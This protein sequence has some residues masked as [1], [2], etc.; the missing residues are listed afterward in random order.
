MNWSD[1]CTYA[2]VACIGL[3][4]EQI[5]TVYTLIA[6]TVL[7][8]FKLRWFI[9]VGGAIFLTKLGKFKVRVVWVVCN[10]VSIPQALPLRV[11]ANLTV[12]ILII[13][14]IVVKSHEFSNA[15]LSIDSEMM[16]VRFRRT[17]ACQEH[18]LVFHHSNLSH[19]FDLESLR[20]S[21]RALD[22]F[23]DVFAIFEK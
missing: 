3:T 20:P 7:R 13:I 14:K 5:I 12:S 4:S 22:Y 18:C 15:F 23:F 17:R 16:I 10:A 2:F 9:A 19:R 8:I 11:R 21:W 6:L 1:I